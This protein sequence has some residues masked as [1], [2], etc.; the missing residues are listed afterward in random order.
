MWDQ[1]DPDAMHGKWS[2]LAL[3]FIVP[4]LL[5]GCAKGTELLGARSVER[6]AGWPLELMWRDS[7]IFNLYRTPNVDKKFL[8]SY[9]VQ[10]R[11]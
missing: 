6:E 8:A 5:E 11:L 3:R 2:V 10:R 7:L 9:L 4:A 1:Q